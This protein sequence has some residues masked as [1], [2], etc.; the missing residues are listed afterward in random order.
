MED[1][2]LVRRLDRDRLVLLG[3]EAITSAAKWEREGWTCRSAR[4]LVCLGLWF[5]GVP[6]RLIARAY[7]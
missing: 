6:P 5:A 1:V 2:D 3:A 4:N 7:G